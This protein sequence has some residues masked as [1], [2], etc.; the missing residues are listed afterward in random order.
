MQVYVF[1][2]FT[3]LS[4]EMK[5]FLKPREAQCPM[6]LHH[7]LVSVLSFGR[8]YGEGDG[9]AGVLDEAD[10]F[11]V[12][13]VADGHVVDGHDGVAHVEVTTPS[14][15]RVRDQLTWENGCL[16]N[17]SFCLLLI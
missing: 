7:M 5:R 6:L 2:N 12:G 9:G 15:G 11:R 8:Q 3:L 17:D 10:H 4:L 13:Q 14:G 16:I 1:I